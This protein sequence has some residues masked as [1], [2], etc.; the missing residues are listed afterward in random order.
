MPGPVRVAARQRCQEWHEVGALRRGWEVFDGRFRWQRVQAGLEGEK[1]TL[2]RP[3]LRGTNVRQRTHAAAGDG[4]GPVPA[5]P[6]V[7]DPDRLGQR[8]HLPGH[9]VQPADDGPRRPLAIY[10]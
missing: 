3:I 4:F 1:A 5:A 9:A 7:A 6:T 10:S 8:R 2:V